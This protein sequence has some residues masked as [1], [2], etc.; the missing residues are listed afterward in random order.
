MSA[1]ENRRP[2]LHIVV[3]PRAQQPERV[4]LPETVTDRRP[5]T[6]DTVLALAKAADLCGLDGVVLPA[7]PDEL[8]PWVLAAHLLRRTRYVSVFLPVEPGIATPQYA[9]KFTASLQRFSA[10]RAGWI[11]NADAASADVVSTARNFWA[12]PEGLPPVLTAHAFPHVLV[13]GTASVAQL[14]TA[15]V[16]PDALATEIQRLA[17]SGAEDVLLDVAGDP[18]EVLRLGERVLPALRARTLTPIGADHVG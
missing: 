10:G 2:R 4:A 1:E 17:A 6:A 14:A 3:P 13:T 11:V 12:S 15:G 18:G 7:G 9:A 16:A 8:E 5:A